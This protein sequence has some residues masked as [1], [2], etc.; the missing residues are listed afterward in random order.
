MNN[1]VTGCTILVSETRPFCEKAASSLS[2]I[3]RSEWVERIES[4]RNQWPDIAELS[5][6][7]GINPNLFLHQL[8][9]HSIAAAAY[10]ADV[11]QHQM[12]AAQS[13]ELYNNQRF[14]TSG[15]MGAM[16][17]AL[18]CAIGACFESNK[19]VVV[20]A[21]DGGF[22]LNIQ[23]LQ[24]IARNRLPLKMVVIN[25]QCHGMVRQFQDSYFKGRVQSTVWGYSAPSFTALARAYGISSSE[26]SDPEQTTAAVQSLWTNPD[27]PYLLEVHI[28]L[29]ANAYPK[30]AFGRP[31]SEMEPFAQP[32]EMEGT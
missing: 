3:S 26:V 10:V 7:E 6:I 1:R 15:G 21:G 16:G 8:S 32:L 25:N 9:S 2:E 30:M 4:L 12:W 20:I 28:A 22:Q 14:L 17:F 23:E 31:I 19:P 27:E 13:L 5:E 11:G 24:T 18:P 29:K